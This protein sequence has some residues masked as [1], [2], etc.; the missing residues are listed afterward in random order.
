MGLMVTGKTMRN[1]LESKI[2]GQN[3]EDIL[4]MSPI[5]FEDRDI[6]IIERQEGISEIEYGFETDL[7]IVDST[8]LIKLMNMPYKINKPKINVGR[9]PEDSGEI[10]LDIELVKKGFKLGD[11]ISF[12]KE[13]DKFSLL[14]EEENHLKDYTYR[15][16]GFCQSVEYSNNEDKGQSL[17]GFGE[18][19]GIA[20]I[21]S[22][23]FNLD[24]TFARLKY[25]DTKGLETFSKEYREKVK[26]HKNN[27]DIEFKFR[28]ED[29]LNTIKSEID[30]EI[31]KGQN[32]IADA[33]NKLSDAKEEITDAEKELK[34][35]K[36]DYNEGKSEFNKEYTK[37]KSKLD[38]AKDKLYRS[39]KDIDKGEKDLIEGYN[40]LKEGREKLD[41][42]KVDLQVGK[43]KYRQGK[44]EYEQGLGEIKAREEQLEDGKS[45]LAEGRKK[46]DEGQAEIEKSKLELEEGQREIA[47]NEAKLIESEKEL[48]DGIEE[49]ARGV[50]LPGASIDEVEER[51]Y[52]L[53]TL[54]EESEKLFADYKPLTEEIKKTEENISSLNENI[55]NTNENISNIEIQLQDPNLSQDQRESLEKEIK[56][57][58][59]ELG[60]I[61]ESL[62]R[63]KVK[64]ET[65]KASKEVLKKGIE[66]INNNLPNGMT[67]EGLVVQ[68]KEAKAGVKK[69]R[70]G[71]REIELGKEKLNAAKEKI[72]D[73]QAQLEDGIEELRKGELEYQANKI[74]LDQGKEDLK[75]GKDELE[76]ARK[77]LAD[78]KSEIIEGEEDFTEG[79]KEYQENYE[80]YL[81]GKSDL[82][83]GKT[84]F[85]EGRKTLKESEEEFENEIGKARKE[86]NEASS[87]LYKGEKEL[88]DGKREFEEQSEEASKKIK[89]GN[90]KIEDAKK[91]LK[92][93]KQ[94]RYNIT[95]RYDNFYLNTYFEGADRMDLLSYIFPVFFFLISMLVSF[96]TMTRMVEEERILIGTYKALGYR[97]K[98]I[99]RKFFS[100]GAIASIIGGI[101]GALL[102]SYILPTVIANAYFIGSIFENNLTFKFYP[103]RM[104]LSIFV[105]IIFTGLAAKMSVNKSLKENAAK[106]LRVK[107]PKSG[108][109]IGLEKLPFIWNR[110]S[111][112]YKVTARNLF[113]YKKRVIMT[114]VGIMGCT[115]L[116]VLG[117][118]IKGSI[119]GIGDIQFKE[120]QKYNLAVT[121][122]RDIDEESY[123]NYKEF[124]GNKK[125]DYKEFLQD[126]L[127][128]EYDAIN[129]D[130]LLVVPKEENYMDDYFI[131]RDR[132]SHEEIDLP[133]NGAVISE[134][135]AKI[136]N[137]EIGDLVE[138]K[139][140][141]NKSYK[142]EVK[143]IT[144][145]YT[146]HYVFMDKQYYEKVFGKDFESNCDYIKMDKSEKEL[147]KIASD[148]TNY[149][150]VVSVLDLNVLE[151]TMDKFM[152]SITKV[153]VII[154]IAS[155]LLAMV[156]LYNLTNINIEER[157]REISTIKVLGFRPNE[158]TKY[159]YRET[160]ILTI[161]GII[162]GLGIGKVL[163]YYVMRVVAPNIMM[164]NPTLKIDS[165]LRAGLITLIVSIVIMLIFHRKLNK[166]DMVESLKSNE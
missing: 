96:T 58:K 19:N 67:I 27:L 93:L 87:K 82:D 34:E 45:Q 107:P 121:Y 36:K 120:L 57:L 38:E 101:I 43:T 44:D 12:S 153:Q 11:T 53:S 37:G 50:G 62:K 23:E 16:V 6:G 140:L 48:N 128:L 10:L 91:V 99:S 3:Y 40:K 55:A 90:E 78:A 123:K 122:D 142:V 151:N 152:Y 32:K 137:L 33:E 59:T 159:I 70:S 98:E 65:L 47:K 9:A 2:I 56:E 21:S 73:G 68:I 119:S 13:V 156:V 114:I 143:A 76:D 105:G 89:E 133:T 46:L 155:S 164:F 72:R 134:K 26:S 54:V 71:Q 22:S 35:G 61:E 162:I 166:I 52:F 103:L 131:L 135:L 158:I 157:L 124:L 4:I 15:I 92:I 5:G 130:V 20:Y 149:K 111:F 118:G 106:L 160:G 60:S 116:L 51:V 63:E 104:L 139:D 86:L 126:R 145:M 1:T 108:N 148:F 18:I 100:Y 75:K 88:E 125:Y 7:R 49:L 97:N 127:V 17:R 83:A 94:P 113:R 138:F 163:H 66:E 28:P 69:I 39:E 161:I 95:P 129:Q 30:D 14:D 41:K 31:E 117:F 136:K 144:E 77:K 80:K 85:V 147:E 154:T 79:K 42:A 110:L 74:K 109:R 165:Y 102:G 150:S 141:D 112:L 81:E 115:A 146:G 8:D 25:K 24:P 29:R 64:L 132:S 84:S